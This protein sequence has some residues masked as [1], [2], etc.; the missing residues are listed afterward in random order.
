MKRSSVRPSVSL[1]VCL[2]IRQQPRRVAG[3]QLSAVQAG[4]NRSTAAAAAAN[5]SSVTLTANV[6]S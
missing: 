5:A 1:S 4:N 6:G 2:V 3:L